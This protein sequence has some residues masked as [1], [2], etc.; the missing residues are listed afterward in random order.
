MKCLCIFLFSRKHYA[1]KKLEEKSGN[2]LGCY[3]LR[4]S[5]TQYDEFFLDLIVNVNIPDMGK[6][7]TF[8]IYKDEN[9]FYFTEDGSYGFPS[10]AQLLAHLSK[11]INISFSRCIPPS[12]YGKKQ[13]FMYVCVWKMNAEVVIETIFFIAILMHIHP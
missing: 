1:Y 4:E 6:I 2:E 5:E 10:I 8:K 7:L 12:E 13:V 9:D 11:E 3:L